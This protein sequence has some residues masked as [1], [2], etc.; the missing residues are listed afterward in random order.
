[1]LFRIFLWF[2]N[3]NVRSGTWFSKRRT[4]EVT[5]IFITHIPFVE[6][7][8]SNWSQTWKSEWRKLKPWLVI[9]LISC[10][11]NKFRIIDIRFMHFWV[12]WSVSGGWRQSLKLI[13]FLSTFA[14]KRFYFCCTAHPK[15]FFRNF[16]CPVLCI[17]EMR[18]FKD[19]KLS[20]F[21]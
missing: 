2:M 17:N 18:W 4:F 19:L 10:F 11:T 21:Q 9:K 20:I 15:N 8:F 16:D 13:L 6:I 7:S 14:E 5:F 12:Q 3:V 1:M